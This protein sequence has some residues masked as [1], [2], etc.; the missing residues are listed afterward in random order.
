MLSASNLLRRNDLHAHKA[1]A[2]VTC[3]STIIELTAMLTCIPFVVTNWG[4]QR[5]GVLNPHFD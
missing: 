4:R 3:K 2:I 1:H 5:S